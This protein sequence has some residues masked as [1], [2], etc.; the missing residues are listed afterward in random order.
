MRNFLERAFNI[1]PRLIE[2]RRILHRFPELSGQEFRTTELIRKTL[3]EIGVEIMPWEGKTGVV[4]L[5]QGALPGPTVALRA[6]IDA[7]RVQE[8]GNEEYRSECPGIMHACGHDIH[9][10]C[11]LG[12]AILLAGDRSSLAGAVK[13]IFE[14]GEEISEGASALIAGKALENPKVEAIFGLHTQPDLR[15]GTV[16]ILEGPLMAAGDAIFITVK[17]KGG[18]GGYPHKT[19]DPIVAAAAVI[20]AIQNIVSRQT[21]PLETIVISLGTLHAGEVRNVIPDRWEMTGNVRSFL[22][23]LREE[24]PDRIRIAITHAAAS[25]GCEIDF[26]YVHRNPPVINPIALADFARQSLVKVFGSESIVRP[27]PSMGAEDFSLFQEKIPGMF[28]WLGTGSGILDP[29]NFWHSPKFHADEK[30]L[31]YGAAALAQLASDY[32]ASNR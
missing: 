2:Y 19:R 29:D 32:L 24:L 28:I 6:D 4:G 23:A 22:P 15:L 17:G 27:R 20:Q 9:T 1:L 7:I 11:L 30:S 8:D 13:L 16:G 10:A 31:A 14:P 5:L 3:Q 21:D 18:H 25:M 26:R 12:A